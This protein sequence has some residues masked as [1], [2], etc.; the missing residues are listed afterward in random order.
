MKLYTISRLGLKLADLATDDDPDDEAAK[1]DPSSAP[2]DS[3]VKKGPDPGGDT[4][5]AADKEEKELEA[6]ARNLLEF[7]FIGRAE[8]YFLGGRD[9]KWWKYKMRDGWKLKPQI[10]DFDDLVKGGYNKTRS[11]Y[12]RLADLAAGSHFP[13]V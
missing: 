2:P 10:G 1:L 3:A 7:S 13:R 6:R 12:L 8:E 11:G 5:D 9:K 4:D